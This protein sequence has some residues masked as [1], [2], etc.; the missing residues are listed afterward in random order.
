PHPDAISISIDLTRRYT[1]SHWDSLLLG[2]CIVAGVDTLYSEDMSHNGVY[3]S[4]T[5]IN[6]FAAA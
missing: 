2:A 6:P 5:V 1:L 4:V 3:D